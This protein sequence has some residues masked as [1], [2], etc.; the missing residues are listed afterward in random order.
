[1]CFLL[2]GLENGLANELIA[3]LGSSTNAFEVGKIPRDEETSTYQQFR[4]PSSNMRTH[5]LIKL[6]Q[7]LNPLPA[8]LMHITATR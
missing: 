6:E 3:G 4:T 1:M 2:D 5:G 8:I 7:R